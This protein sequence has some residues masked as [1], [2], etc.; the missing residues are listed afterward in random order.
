[1]ICRPG[2]DIKLHTGCGVPKWGTEATL[3]HN[4]LKVTLKLGIVPL[5]SPHDYEILGCRQA[6]VSLSHG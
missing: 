5:S 6:G 3:C 4:C 1:M 2:Y